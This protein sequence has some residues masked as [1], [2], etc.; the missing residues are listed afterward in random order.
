MITVLF[1]NPNSVYKEIGVDCYDLVRNVN[2][3]SWD[4]PVIAHPPCRQFSKI[5]ALSKKDYSEIDMVIKTAIHVRNYGGI[6][7]HPAGSKLW[8]VLNMWHWPG[9]TL[10]VNQHWF[11]FPA[12]KKTWLYFSG[13]DRKDV[14]PLP[15]NFDYPHRK[16]VN[17]NKK[18][19][20]VTT[21]DFA[22]WLIGNLKLCRVG[23]Q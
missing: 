2:T 6:L 21:G 9:F 3:F 12:Q 17:M 4:R 5:R 7:E 10:S 14:L 11:G 23:H 16:V 13:I 19:R 18:D 1:V 20:A 8:D 15:L 22:Y